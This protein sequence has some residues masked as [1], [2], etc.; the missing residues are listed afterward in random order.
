[1]ADTK[2]IE[3][4]TVIAADTSKEA[5]VNSEGV[6]PEKGAAENRDYAGAVAKTDPV[7]IRLVRKLDYRIM[8]ILVVMYFLNYIDRNTL[9]QARL[10]DVEKEL[11]MEGEFQFNTTISILFVGY[12]LMQ[13]PSNML[14]TRVSPSMYM[15]SWMVVWSIVSACTSLVQSYAGMVVCRFLLGVT[16]APFY[17]GATYL[18]AIFYTRKEVASRIAVL[19]CAQILATG[20]AGLIAAGVFK[21]MDDARGLSGWRWLFIIE[22]CIT[23]AVALIGFWLLPDTPLTTRWLKPDER[24]L[25][26]ARIERDKMGQMGEESSVMEGLRQAAKDKRTWIFSLMQNFHLAACGFN[27]YF[28]TVV[29]TLGFP[30]TETLL[31]TCPPFIFAACSAIFMGW[32]SGHYHERTWHITIGL[33]VAVVGFVI[34][35]T[36]LNTAGRYIA[37]FIFPVGAYSVNSVI[38]GW[39]SST[40]SQTREKRAVV[41]AMH[42]VAGQ[43]GYIYG[44]YIW[45]NY[46][47]PRFAI[48]F[49]VSAGL[50]LGAIGCAWWMRVILQKENRRLKES[51]GGD[52]INYYGY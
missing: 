48:G 46:D 28:P 34:A 4:G 3:S 23:T 43:I 40:L 8:P 30:K 35:C 26:H 37:C 33:F 15:S 45:P 13:I 52:E 18:L 25:A 11:G 44:A 10:D 1:M 14:I 19:Y 5:V 29:R 49:G 39:V 20:F 16:E 42:N 38:I 12:V 31:L 6:F 9:A 22:G 27:S 41:L 21:G 24:Q 50:A 2:H 36:T 7:E 17:P 32:S 47:K 51:G